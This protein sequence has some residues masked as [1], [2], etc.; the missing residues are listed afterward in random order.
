MSGLANKFETEEEVQ[1]KRQKRQD[2]WEKVR[3]PDDPIEAPE[4]ETRSLFEQLQANKDFKERELE[5]EQ[6]L[7]SS[8]K[9]LEDDE[10]QFLNYVSNRQMQI[11][12]DRSREEMSVIEELNSKKILTLEEKQKAAASTTSQAPKASTAGKKSQM[13]LLSGAIKRRSTDSNTGTD[14]KKTK[15]DDRASGDKALVSGLPASDVMQ[16]AGVLPGIGDYDSDSSTEASSQSSDSE[17]DHQVLPSNSV[18]MMMADLKKKW[19]QQNQA[20]G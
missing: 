4:E 1:E 7:R 6:K 3:K 12:K 10:V 8:V 9:G 14:N 17:A 15:T 20:C 2:E 5:E 16:M 18:S 19:K 11:E 13:Q